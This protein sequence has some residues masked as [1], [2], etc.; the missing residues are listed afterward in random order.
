[1][2]L[3]YYEHDMFEILYNERTIRNITF[4]TINDAKN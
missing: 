1:M 4:G 3:D 2:I